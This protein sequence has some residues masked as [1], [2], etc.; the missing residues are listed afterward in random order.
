MDYVSCA[1]IDK[2]LWSLLIAAASAERQKATRKLKRLKKLA[3]STE[4]GTTEYVELREKVHRAQVDLNYSLYYPLNEKYNSLYKQT[5]G[6]VSPDVTMSDGTPSTLGT[7]Q[8][9]PK[10]PM[11]QS[12]NNVWKTVH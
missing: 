3:S 12:W 2:I 6:T 11:W 10:P 1:G 4:P 7:T 9:D 5:E 8:G